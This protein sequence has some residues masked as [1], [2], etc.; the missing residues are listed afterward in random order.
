MKTAIGILLLLYAIFSALINIIPLF[1]HAKLRRAL[2]NEGLQNNSVIQESIAPLFRYHMGMLLTALG[3]GAV[4]F[5][6][7]SAEDLPLLN[8]AGAFIAFL[9][10]GSIIQLLFGKNRTAAKIASR[11]GDLEEFHRTQK[12]LLLYGLV[13]LAIGVFLAL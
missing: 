6:F 13:L 5:F 7:L 1:S 3:A 9:G 11:G 12:F 8:M 10:Y 4:G 2:H